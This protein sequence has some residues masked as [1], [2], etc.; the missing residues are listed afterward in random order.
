MRS[1]KRRTLGPKMSLLS[2]TMFSSVNI[3]MI[4]LEDP[5]SRYCFYFQIHYLEI[6]D[7]L[8]QGKADFGHFSLFLLPISFSYFLIIV[9]IL[10]HVQ[11]P[12]HIKLRYSTGQLNDDA[13]FRKKK[14]KCKEGEIDSESEVLKVASDESRLSTLDIFAGCGGL[15][16]GLEQ[17]GRLAYN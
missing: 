1:E 16:E 3:C 13:T 10:V 5:L 8:G 2:L 11:L 6:S 15:S 17:S 4:L 9:P 14:G 7:P 12:S